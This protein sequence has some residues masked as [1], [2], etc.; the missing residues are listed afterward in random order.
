MAGPDWRATTG[1]PCTWAQKNADLLRQPDVAAISML[2]DVLERGYFNLQD[3]VNPANPD[4]PVVRRDKETG[5]VERFIRNAIRPK[6]YGT[7]SNLLSIAGPPGMGKTTVVTRVLHKVLAERAHADAEV[8]VLQLNGMH[9]ATPLHLFLHMWQALQPCLADA[10]RQDDAAAKPAAALVLLRGV[11]ARQAKHEADERGRSMAGGRSLSRSVRAPST[12]ARASNARVQAPASGPVLSKTL[13]VILDEMDAALSA[14]DSSSLLF[15]LM[16]LLSMTSAVHFIGI[17]NRQHLF[18]AFRHAEE[19][20][21]RIESRTEK[22]QQILFPNYGIPD[23]EA[24]ITARVKRV[25]FVSEAQDRGRSTVALRGTDLV[26]D[27]AVKIAAMVTYKYAGGDCRAALNLMMYAI[28]QKQQQLVTETLRKSA[29][30][31]KVKYFQ[32][33]QYF[34]DATSMHAFQTTFLGGAH[35]QH[36]VTDDEC[37]VLCIIADESK[38]RTGAPPKEPFYVLPVR[39]EL[40]VQ[41]Y[42]VNRPQVKSDRDTLLHPDLSR[43]ARG[44]R[45]AA[46]CPSIGT[47]DPSTWGRH[48]VVRD[49]EDGSDTDSDLEEEL[50]DMDRQVAA[51][52]HAW[53]AVSG[54]MQVVMARECAA[55]LESLCMQNFIEDRGGTVACNGEIL[56]SRALADMVK[57]CGDRIGALDFVRKNLTVADSKY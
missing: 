34:L 12:A 44:Q 23:L 27:K 53:D 3:A 16:D 2:W 31:G 10:R 26:D 32:E 39:K 36:S 21:K 33:K 18:E 56:T 45:C 9:L 5:D 29:R 7:R 4:P 8:E 52:P 20:T 40:V 30:S 48:N 35:Q 57:S 41:R 28:E 13:L 38:R 24:I 22:Y 14:S 49:S 43:E 11:L 47:Y 54:R 37:L 15:D 50:L 6:G 46:L 51:I 25:D 42:Q 55:V 17:S 19:H 1:G